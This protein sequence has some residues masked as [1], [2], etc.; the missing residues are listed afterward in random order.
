MMTLFVGAVVDFTF[1]HLVAQCF[2]FFLAG[3]ETSSSALCFI[4]YEL[5]EQQNVQRKLQEEV[6]HVLKKHGGHIT[7][8]SLQ[9]MPFMDQVF[10]GTHLLYLISVLESCRFRKRRDFKIK[11]GG[12][13]FFQPVVSEL[14]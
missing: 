6:D 11:A 3:F 12:E 7:Y 10:N 14:I 1:D 5:A 8:E 4:L 2:I 13:I 9:E